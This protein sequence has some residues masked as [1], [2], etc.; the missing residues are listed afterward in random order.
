VRLTKF[1]HC[2]LAIDV[3]DARLLIDPG[4]F[5]SRF[6][7]LTG[8]TGVLITHSHEDHLD[9]NRLHALLGTNPD[10]RVVCDEASA[11]PLAECGVAHHVVHS[12][13]H[14]D[15]GVSIRVYGQEH[16]VTHPDLPNV[17]NVGDMVDDRFFYP[18]DAFTVPD[19]PVE[20]LAV[21]VGAPGMKLSEAVDYLRTVQ[22]RVAM[23]SRT[24]GALGPAT[25]HDHPFREWEIVT[26]GR[27]NE[28]GDAR[29]HL[30][31]SGTD[32]PIA[33]PTRRPERR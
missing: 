13:D 8:L 2:C 29:T 30:I 17:P 14:L 5:S 9:I 18:G 4:C 27:A 10:A 7:G 12:G 6:E 32:Q 11:A 19:V 16:A 1:G 22:P 26:Q 20:V 25:G 28:L 23:A 15:L 33:S 31:L 3:A 21:P 24:V